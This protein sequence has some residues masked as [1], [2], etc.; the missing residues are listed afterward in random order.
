MDK[1]EIIYYLTTE[2]IQTVANDEF[3]RDLS[4]EEIEKVTEA[5][6]INL[7]WYEIISRSISDSI[8]K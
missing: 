7:P 6:H 2:D 1:S 5:I 8:I 3:E 4:V